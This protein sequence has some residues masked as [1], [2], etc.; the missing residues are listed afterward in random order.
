MMIQFPCTHDQQHNI[1]Q[2]FGLVVQLSRFLT[3]VQQ[4][5]FPKNTVENI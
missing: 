2:Q 5:N 3:H 1:P 4:Q